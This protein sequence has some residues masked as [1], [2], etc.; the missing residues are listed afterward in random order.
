MQHR[1]LRIGLGGLR[2]TED[3][4]NRNKIR[5]FHTS[6]LIY[7]P[8]WRGHEKQSLAFLTSS[9]LSAMVALANVGHSK[10]SVLSFA[11]VA[12]DGRPGYV[13][14]CGIYT[15]FFAWCLIRVVRLGFL[16]SL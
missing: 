4:G 14:P 12:L 11:H 6:F 3:D 7:I 13:A 15:P 8:S 2:A 1:R 10:N 9:S 5:L 16:D